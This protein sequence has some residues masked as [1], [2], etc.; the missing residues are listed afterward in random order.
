MTSNKQNGWFCVDT[1][2][3]FWIN[4][5]FINRSFCLS[6]VYLF[7][8]TRSSSFI[9]YESTVY[10]LC[11]FVAQTRI[12]YI[13]YIVHKYTLM[14]MYIHQLSS[15]FRKNYWGGGGL[16]PRDIW[17]FP[18]GGCQRHIFLTPSLDP[19]MSHE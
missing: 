1:Y 14:Y 15:E 4:C 17:V 7:T 3:K 16:V 13:L 8:I 12:F 2:I 9:N 18:G 19:R 6:S 10:L 5:I 11:N